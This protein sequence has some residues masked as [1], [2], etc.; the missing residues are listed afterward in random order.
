M[1]HGPN[2]KTFRGYLIRSVDRQ[3]PA[4]HF[5]VDTCPEREVLFRTWSSDGELTTCEMNPE[6]AIGLAKK[7]Q[8]YAF[9]VIVRDV[10]G[11]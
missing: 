3:G 2:P 11:S 4:Y 1:S 9:L 7:L 6:E 5:A 10:M 8:D